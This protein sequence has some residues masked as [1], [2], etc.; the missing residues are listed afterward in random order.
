M[1]ES[2]RK[3][4]F[5]KWMSGTSAFTR[6]IQLNYSTPLALKIQEEYNAQARADFLRSF[7]DDKYANRTVKNSA[8]RCTIEFQGSVLRVKT[9]RIQPDKRKVFGGNWQDGTEKEN[10]PQPNKHTI[11]EFSRSSR[12]TLQDKLM[13]LSD[14]A[15]VNCKFVTL[16]YHES[17]PAPDVAKSHLRAFYKRVVRY[18]EKRPTLYAPAMFWRIE[19]K[20]RQSGESKYKPAPHFHLFLFGTP[21]IPKMTLLRWWHEITGDESITQLYIRRLDNRRKVMNYVSKY[22]SKDEAEGSLPILD[23]A[24]YLADVGRHWGF[25]GK[26]NIPFAPIQTITMYWNCEQIQ[27]FVRFTE[28]LYPF[29]IDR[30]SYGYKLFFFGSEK[31]DIVRQV[32]QNLIPDFDNPRWGWV[33]ASACIR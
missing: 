13:S 14:N 18:C 31:R 9:H 32:Y 7:R 30:W 12:R 22:V 6:A 17:I 33:S 24:L 16:T 25:E 3:L 27:Q 10:A 29:L 19:V 8:T 21:Y 1:K 23:I 11:T 2:S 4:K 28:E 15:L 5:V 20:A 26:E